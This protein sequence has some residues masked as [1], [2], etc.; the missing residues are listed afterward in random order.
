MTGEDSTRSTPGRAPTLA[1]RNSYSDS[2]S[3]Q[4]THA[5][6]LVGPVVATA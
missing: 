1:V 6:R 3:R 2:A 5:A 4:T